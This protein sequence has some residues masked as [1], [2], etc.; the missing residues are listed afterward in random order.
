MID[1]RR[2]YALR[3]FPV[4]VLRERVVRTTRRQRGINN[5]KILTRHGGRVVGSSR[6]LTRTYHARSKTTAKIIRRRKRKRDVRLTKVFKR[7]IGVF[8]QSFVAPA[9][10]ILF[11]KKTKQK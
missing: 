9:R 7:S 4:L 10:R 11:I 3:G 6:E 8:V 5:P 1:V 2:V